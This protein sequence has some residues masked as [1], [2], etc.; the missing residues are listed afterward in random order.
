MKIVTLSTYPFDTPRHGGQHRLANIVAEYKRARHAVHSIGIL[1]ADHYAPSAGFLP[2]PTPGI[3]GSYLDNTF[4]MEDWAIGRWA[5]SDDGGYAALA[6]LVPAGVD[7]LHVEQ[8]WLF[9]FALRYAAQGRRRVR[10]VYGSQNIEYRLKEE[11]VASYLGPKHARDCAER[12][13]ACELAALGAADLVCTVSQ[14]DADW[15]RQH[16]KAPVVLAPNGVAARTC[17]PEDL[18]AANKLT[19]H[20]KYALYCASAHPPNIVGFYDLFGAGIGCLAPNER[21]VVAGS[22]GPAILSAPLARKTPGL[23]RHLACSG[24]ISEGALSALLQLAHALVLPITHGGG[25]NLKTAEA[26]WSGHH[27]VATSVAMRGFETFAK[28][29]GV[30]VADDPVQFRTAL[31]LAMAAPPLALTPAERDARRIVLWE[32]CLRALVN[33]VNKLAA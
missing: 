17:A 27:I 21:L 18:T 16:T 20:R 31:R 5:A 30:T 19:G 9:E 14:G 6:A 7:V 15:S 13:Q 33:H 11:I 3:L 29:R 24:E 10:I 28:D 1:G 8:P 25:T 12:V 23:T 26:L 32:S 4:L 2:Y 22:A